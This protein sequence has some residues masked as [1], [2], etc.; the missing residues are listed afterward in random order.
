MINA[1]FNIS[2]SSTGEKRAGIMQTESDKKL[3]V[4][5]PDELLL[6]QEQ[7]KNLERRYTALFRLNQLSQE[8]DDLDDFYP[9]VHRTIASLMTASNFFIVSYDQT[10]STVE[11][12]YYVDEKDPKPEVLLIMVI[13]QD[14]LLTLLLSRCNHY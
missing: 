7:Y 6:L 2:A 5:K 10:F 4:N 9:Q 13:F 8:C 14:H 3:E 11:F 1:G 12:V